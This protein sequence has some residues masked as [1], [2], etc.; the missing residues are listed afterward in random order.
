MQGYV[1]A[2]YES[3]Q[4]PMKDASKLEQPVE[5]LQDHLL[6]ECEA[7][8]KY[9]FASGMKVPATVTQTLE[10]LDQYAGPDGGEAASAR[11]ASVARPNLGVR[12]LAHVHEQ[13]VRLVAPATPRTILLLETEQCRHGFWRFLGSVPLIRGLMLAAVLFLVAL[14]G[15]S[16]PEDVNG[17]VNWANEHGWK[18]LLEELFL[19]SAAGVGATFAALF[20]ANRYVVEGTF[21]PKFNSTYWT[22][23][24][25]GVVAGMI[26]AMLV[27]IEEGGHIP[28]V[29]KPTLAMLGGF[30]VAVVYRILQRL[31]E[32]VESLVRG[33]A[34]EQ[35][36]AREL[37]TEARFAEEAAQGRLRVTANLTHLQQQLASDASREDLKERLERLIEE[38]NPGALI[39]GERTGASQQD[40][41]ASSPLTD[42]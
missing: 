42:R 13:L 4:V 3:R 6:K 22:R 1:L 32:T 41:A 23:I 9:A 37:A 8:A 12:R 28:E 2:I 26:L 38:L 29:A 36:A 20:R 5:S 15:A 35:I 11:G 39:E 14:I 18:L 24:V 34:R 10:A 30:S 27:P 7:M 19:I 21:D 16:L 17:H 31:V 40:E 25:L 33:D